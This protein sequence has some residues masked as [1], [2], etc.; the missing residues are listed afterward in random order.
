MRTV[1]LG[2]VAIAAAAT[3]TVGASSSQAGSSP[4]GT[5]GPITVAY[6]ISGTWAAGVS[7]GGYQ[8]T[9]LHVAYSS[10]IRG[11]AVFAGGA[12]YCAQ[13]NLNRALMACMNDF[14]DDQVPTLQQIA[15][16]WSSQ[17]RIDP[18]GNLSGDRAYLYHGTN[19]STVKASVSAGL[20]AF[21]RHFGVNVV[22]NNSEP[23][24]HSWVSPR[25]PNPCTS[26]YPPYLNRC[27]TDPQGALLRHLL[28]SV[29]APNT[30]TLGG[31]VLT[32][33]QNAYA[34]G[35]NA[36]AINMD[37]T[38]FVYVPQSCAGGAT[39][40]LVVAL[41]GCKQGYATIGRQF[42]DNSYLN[43]YADTNG[44]VI[45]YPQAVA[46]WMRNPNGCWD[47]WGYLGTNYAQRGAP[48]LA[49]IM[50]M[51]RGLGG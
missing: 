22:D 1:R 9:Q 43:Q 34:P 38:G 35:G 26:S 32:V 20:A 39:C 6:S 15:S 48:Q 42:V 17:G 30:G 29:D 3:V 50:A 12:Y 10:T 46:D 44:L 41:H 31:T 33:D 5:T 11:A 18:I 37:R 28:G 27:G 40:R 2:I 4:A 23:A 49:T 45:L 19:D 51:V 14:Y 13:G 21:Y 16:S 7:S 25:G 24:G 8:A 47:W 36:T